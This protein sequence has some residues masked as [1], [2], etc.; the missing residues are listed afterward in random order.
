MGMGCMINVQIHIYSRWAGSE[1]KPIAFSF[2]G[3]NVESIVDVLEIDRNDI[4]VIIVNGKHARITDPV[5]DGSV[6][7]FMPSIEGG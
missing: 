6:I 2:D 1:R 4:G 7:F 5:S 3:Q